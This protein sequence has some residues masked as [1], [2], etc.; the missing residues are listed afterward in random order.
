M[1]SAFELRGKTGVELFHTIQSNPVAETVDANNLSTKQV[2]YGGTRNA[3]IIREGREEFE[4]EIDVILT[5]ATLLHR[6]RSHLETGGSERNWQLNSSQ[7]HKANRQ[8]WRR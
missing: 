7:L 5:D 1:V 4:M 2:P 3:S 6:L 8:W